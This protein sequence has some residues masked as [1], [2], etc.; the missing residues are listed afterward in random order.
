MWDWKLSSEMYVSK[1]LIQEIIFSSLLQVPQV[2]KF[3]G[4]SFT[5]D[6]KNFC[7]RVEHHISVAICS[8]NLNL[9]HIYS[10]W[11]A[12][13]HLSTNFIGWLRGLS[14]LC[15][16]V[17]SLHLEGVRHQDLTPS[18]ILFD[19]ENPSFPRAQLLDFATCAT[20][21]RNVF[22][23]ITKNYAAPELFLK[24]KLIW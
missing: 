17:R 11:D 23:G 3:Y 2:P 5:A 22:T 9:E 16:A 1:D 24:N 21:K 20:E 18:N 4:V 19:L 7:D 10:F 8:E 15:Q 14:S 13:K 6:K 12:F